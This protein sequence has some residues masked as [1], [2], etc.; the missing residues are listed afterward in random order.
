MMKL[1]DGAI[2]LTFSHSTEYFSR[3][4]SSIMLEVRLHQSSWRL[5]AGA[6]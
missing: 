1:E 3:T 5:A 4:T 2:S 6:S